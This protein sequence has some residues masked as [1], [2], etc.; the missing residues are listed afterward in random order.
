MVIIVTETGV[1]VNTE[2][3]NNNIKYRWTAK[4]HMRDFKTC[5]PA[6]QYEVTL[7]RGQGIGVIIL[8]PLNTYIKLY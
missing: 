7:A 4:S 5:D 3:T 2:N 8:E 6:T 1:S